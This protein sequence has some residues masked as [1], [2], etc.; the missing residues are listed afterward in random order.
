[1]YNQKITIRNI[2]NILFFIGLFF[3]PFNSFDGLKYFGEYK[4]ES[5]AYF[6]FAGFI[7]LIVELL[8]IKRVSIPL[9]NLIYKIPS[10]PICLNKYAASGRRDRQEKYIIF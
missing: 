7:I 4:N 10:H 1:M 6:F 3:F 5:A 2:Y 8:I 9:N